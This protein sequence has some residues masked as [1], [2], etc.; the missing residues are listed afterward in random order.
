[1]SIM[2][3]EGKFR[4]KP[5]FF[6][7]FPDYWKDSWGEKPCLGI[8]AAESE[9]HAERRAYDKGLLPQ[10][11]TICPVATEAPDV[12]HHNILDKIQELRHSGRR[13]R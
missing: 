2:K 11:F 1:M 9:F 10:N 7:I 8:V 12:T 3:R 5:K 6:Y 4:S 13:S